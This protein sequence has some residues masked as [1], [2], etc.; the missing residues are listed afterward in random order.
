MWSK[1][2]IVTLFPERVVTLVMSEYSSNATDFSLLLITDLLTLILDI[3]ERL[4]SRERAECLLY[5]E[6]IEI[7]SSESSLMWNYVPALL[8]FKSPGDI[9]PGPKFGLLALGDFLVGW[10][11]TTND[12][13]VGWII[14]MNS[15]GFFL[16]FTLM[17]EVSEPSWTIA[18]RSFNELLF[19][20][21]FS[22]GGELG[23]I[24]F[25]EN[26]YAYVLTA[27]KFT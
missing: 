26:L 25:D 3:L 5:L 1:A 22:V 6:I 27:E 20:V 18:S 15:D 14:S 4:V 10:I 19:R 9:S 16:I 24:V 17:L 23:V 11:I 7:S 13:L 21:S 2:A 12:F 8:K